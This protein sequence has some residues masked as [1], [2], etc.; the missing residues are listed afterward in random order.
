MEIPSIPLDQFTCDVT[1]RC[2]TGCRCVYRPANATLHVYC[3][4]SNLTKLPTELPPLP[5]AVVRYKMDLRNNPHLTVIED[6]DYF[7]NLSTLDASN[8]GVEAVDP[9]A[10]RHLVTTDLERKILLDGNRLKTLPHDGVTSINVSRRVFISLNDNP[11]SCLCNNR[12]MIS[13]L[14]SAEEHL[15]YSDGI[16]CDSPKRLRGRNVFRVPDEEFCIDPAIALVQKVIP[17][18]IVA[19]VV[20]MS[21]LVIVAYR[22]RFFMFARWKFHPFDRDECVGEDMEYDVFL[23][24]S[25]E[26]HIVSWNSN[27]RATGIERLSRLLSPTRLPGRSRDY[28][29]HLSRHRT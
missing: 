8:S 1:E 5:K 12:W 2:P 16:L 19:V 21:T 13:W 29:Q 6:R 18:S 20:V 24:C 10:W 9:K 28:R 22:L 14:K 17:I 4:F 27:L 11:W 7:T 3:S 23:C 26:D 15:M 25:S